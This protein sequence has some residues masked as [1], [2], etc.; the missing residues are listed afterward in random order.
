VMRIDFAADGRS[1]LPTSS[2]L[3]P[4]AKRAHALGAITNAALRRS[5]ENEKSVQIIFAAPDLHA[6]ICNAQITVTNDIR[7]FG[8][9][10]DGATLNTRALQA[11]I[12]KCSAAGGGTV[13]WPEDAT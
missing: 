3:S 10:G 6:G 11:A 13:L 4:C 12:D 1:R 9:V 5:L 7:A 8:A 2:P